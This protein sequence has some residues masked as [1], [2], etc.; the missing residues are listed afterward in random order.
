MANG[1]PQ[2]PLLL[3]TSVEENHMLTQ[4]YSNSNFAIFALSSVS[5][6]EHL[7]PSLKPIRK[8]VLFKLEVGANNLIT[9]R[10][11][12]LCEHQFP[13]LTKVVNLFPSEGQMICYVFNGDDGTI[14][15]SSYIVNINSF[16]PA[17]SKA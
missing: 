17:T 2:T 6:T 5:V 15:M 3:K 14:K 12:L 8:V 16:E 13:Q 4:V 7:I 9:C 1:F 11:L 10:E